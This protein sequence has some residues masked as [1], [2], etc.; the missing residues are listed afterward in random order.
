MF[1]HRQF[2]D[3][4][5]ILIKINW[6]L[7]RQHGLPWW[8][9]SKE[10]ACQGRRHR[11]HPCSGKTPRVSTQLSPRATAPE[12]HTPLSP[13]PTVRTP[14]TRS[15]WPQ[16]RVAPALHNER[17][18]ER[19]NEDPCCQNE[20]LEIHLKKIKTQLFCSIHSVTHMCIKSLHCAPENY[21]LIIYIK[22]ISIKLEKKA[23]L[24]HLG[25]TELGL[26]IRHH[27]WIIVNCA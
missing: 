11:F 9:K 4:D 1:N 3:L 26:N 24:R 21:M 20:N 19:R 13:C 12:A 15:P 18:P 25:N 14:A 2:A 6:L 27:S 5:W 16:R 23:V 7:K 17:K 8:S 10:T 22:Y